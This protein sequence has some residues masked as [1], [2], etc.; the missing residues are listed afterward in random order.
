MWVR[1]TGAR[2]SGRTGDPGTTSR[3]S[4]TDS[5][6]LVTVCLRVGVE[7]GLAAMVP[8]AARAGLFEARAGGGG[9]GRRGSAR[10][11][12]RLVG[13]PG[14]AGIGGRLG[15]GGPSVAQ[16]AVKTCT[17]VPSGGVRAVLDFVRGPG[18]LGQTRRYRTQMGAHAPIAQS[19]FCGISP[20]GA[21][22]GHPWRPSD[23]STVGL[24]G[25][26]PGSSARTR[27]TTLQK[28]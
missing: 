6:R 8:P 15:K 12:R 19:A 27:C 14:R 22:E 9:K 18:G 11:R 7:L 3:R 4:S 21:H 20:R 24:R 25:D 26:G 28:V 13:L 16:C 1:D 17:R 2:G 10:S 23:R 5:G